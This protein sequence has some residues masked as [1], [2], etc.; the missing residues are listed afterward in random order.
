MIF[1]REYP[2][3]SG[4]LRIEITYLQTGYGALDLPCMNIAEIEYGYE[5]DDLLTFFP[6]VIK[7]DF[8]DLEKKNYKIL[9]KTFDLT[10]PYKPENAHYVKLFLDNGEIFRG[11]IDKESMHYDEKNRTLSF[12]A[13]DPCVDLKNFN[14][15]VYSMVGGNPAHYGD[16]PSII[17]ESFSKVY[18]NTHSGLTSNPAKHESGTT[19]YD[20]IYFQHDWK[21]KAKDI[22]GATLAEADF[23]NVD[24]PPYSVKLFR[25]V[26]QSQQMTYADMIKFIAWEF[27]MIIG[28]SGYGKV[29]AIKRFTKN[30]N[31]KLPINEFVISFTKDLHLKNVKGVINHI[32]QPGVNKISV[33]TF[34]TVDGGAPKNKDEVLEIQSMMPTYFEGSNDTGGPTMFIQ[35]GSSEPRRTLFVNNGGVRD[36]ELPFAD[37][38]YIG[39]ADLLAYWTLESRTKTKSKYEFELRGIKFW[40]HRIY[41]FTENG[42]EVLIRPMVIKKNLLKNTTTLIGLEAS[43]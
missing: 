35:N 38:Q 19:H 42:T 41:K 23:A 24:G 28:V 21:F 15:P 2:I 7:F 40:M 30:F 13:V 9:Q 20:G 37:N 27:G 14:C 12:E 11:K 5:D 39:I 31:N 17:A 6:P 3:A 4:L 33:G 8:S 10:P 43:T 1:S 26:F 32:N 22:H 16:I 36:D 29:F 34:E 18:P 25:N